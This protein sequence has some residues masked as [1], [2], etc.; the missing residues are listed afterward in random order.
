MQ[1]RP[2]LESMWA[3]IP[4]RDLAMW[5]DDLPKSVAITG[6]KL[7]IVK[8]NQADPSAND[9]ASIDSLQA[10]YPQGQLRLFHSD[11]PGHDFWIFTVP[12]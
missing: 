11:I 10:L 6:P 1:G 2:V 3:G 9:Q 7:F 5:H 8:A 12:Q 4:N